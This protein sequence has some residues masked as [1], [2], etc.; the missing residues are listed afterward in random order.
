[1]AENDSIQVH[2]NSKNALYYNNNLTS[3]CNFSLP[4]IYVPHQHYLY[5][6]VIHA[7]IP[8]S[9]YQINSN[10]NTLIYATNNV[11]SQTINIQPIVTITPGNYNA[12]QLAI[13]LTTNMPYITVTYNSISNKFNFIHTS[14]SFVFNSNSTCFGLLGMVNKSDSLISNS[15][16][17]QSYQSIDLSPYKCLCIISNFATGSMNLSAQTNLSVLLSLPIQSNPYSLIT[18]RGDTTNKHCIYTNSISALELKITDQ[19]NNPIDLNGAHWAMTLQLNVIK[20][21]ELKCNYN[22]YMIGMKA[23]MHSSATGNKSYKIAKS[24]GQKANSSSGGIK[25]DGILSPHAEPIYNNT[26]NGSNM[27]Y[28]PFGLKKNNV[29]KRNNTIEKRK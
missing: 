27:T 4:L 18:Y 13:Y 28:E 15:Y 14:S 10:N 21:A 11:N 5:V 26:S 6:S 22:I 29:N 16:Q 3:D 8:Y 25:S 12:R 9:F 24:I 20:F 2:I 1:M 17:L 19:N 23:T 7:V